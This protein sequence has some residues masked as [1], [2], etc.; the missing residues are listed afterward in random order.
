M[1]IFFRLKY[2]LGLVPSAE[3]LEATWEKL[4][5]M[6][7]DLNQMEESD[8]LK[9]FNDLKILI[10]SAPF[11]R[12]R[13]DIES[14]QYQGSNEER[15]ILELKALVKSHQIL[16]YNKIEKSDRLDRFKKIQ[17]GS[18]LKRFSELEKAVE[19]SEFKVRMASHK[20]KEFVKTTDYIVYKEF[21]QLKKS[22]DIRF[23]HK[24]GQSE[25]YLSYLKTVGSKELERLDELSGLTKAVEFNDRVAYLKD[26]KRFLK[27]EEYKSILL[28]KEL[29]KSKFMTDYRK[30]KKA[31]ELAFFDNW[32]I[33]LDESFNEKELNV[34]HWQPENWLGF[35][36]AGQS[37]SQENE[38]Q[39]YN[40]LKNVQIDHSTLVLLA[41]KEKLSGT[42]WN[43]AVGL[44]PKQYDYSSA[45][46]NSA[47][48]YRIKEGVVSAKVRFRK[49]PSVTSAFVLTAEKPFPQIDLFRSTKKGIGMGILEKPGT[50]SSKYFNLKGLND[51]H[52]HIFRLELFNNEL[53]WKINGVEVYRNTCALKD[54]L[55]FSLLTSLHG[56]VSEHLLPHR[57]EIDWIR[58]LAKKS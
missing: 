37:F 15:L 38:M 14:L 25:S 46:I 20:K 41:K 19:S 44:M 30:L 55:F 6:R 29:D 21:V 36:M 33:I 8:E 18:E 27:S 34:K 35:N 56:E 40:G 49:D 13:K 11:I 16:N 23:W 39:C 50:S 48:Y 26:K 28:F 43:P 58:C 5:K 54:P 32:E 3:H 10:D 42:V 24:F 17:D 45:I 52:F 47:G 31:R 57:F 51:S 53:V 22:G 4:I 2:A 7:D 1:S 12:Q 9:Q